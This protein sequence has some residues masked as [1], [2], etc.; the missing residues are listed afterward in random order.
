MKLQQ[1]KRSR[2]KLRLGISG[3]SGVG[4]TYSGLLLAYGITQDWTKIAVIDTAQSSSSIYSDLGNFN[5]LE[6]SAPFSPSRYIEAIEAC[7]NNPNIEI[8]IVDNITH[9]WIGKGGCLDT[10]RKLGGKFQ[11]WLKVSTQHQ[12]FIDKLLQSKCHIITTAKRKINYVIELGANGKAKV[13]NK[14]TKVITRKGFEGNLT[15]DFEIYNKYN[16]VRVTNDRT[17]LF[18]GRKPFVITS[19]IGEELQKWCKSETVTIEEVKLKINQSESILNLMK[20]YKDYPMYQK[21]LHDEFKS[22]K[23]EI[24]KSITSKNLKSD[25]FKGFS[26][27]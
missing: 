8:I 26:A 2:A 3:V 27:N 21:S 6:L 14:G 17:G 12:A 11:D 25:G 9:E 4:K 18:Q 13:V 5:I 7:E 20:L 19:E 15:I 10:H 1:T 22:K 24:E 16:L 23:I